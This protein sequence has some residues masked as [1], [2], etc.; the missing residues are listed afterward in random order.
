MHL[1]SPT[2]APRSNHTENNARLLRQRAAY[3]ERHQPYIA[4]LHLLLD[5]ASLPASK[6][7]QPNLTNMAAMVHELRGLNPEIEG[8]NGVVLGRFLHSILSPLLTWHGAQHLASP[9]F[10]LPPFIS[11][12]STT[13]RFPEVTRTRVLFEAFCVTADWSTDFDQWQAEGGPTAFGI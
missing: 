6:W 9:A 8:L 1:S 10:G 12:E 11:I 7:A 2:T 13:Y 5:R 3:V 4:Y